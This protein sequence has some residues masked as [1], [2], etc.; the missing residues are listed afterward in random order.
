MYVHSEFHIDI[1]R[2]NNIRGTNYF[3]FYA[4]NVLFY[5]KINFQFI[6]NLII[7]WKIITTPDPKL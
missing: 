2:N 7:F 4:H 3:W 5:G 1:E 6:E